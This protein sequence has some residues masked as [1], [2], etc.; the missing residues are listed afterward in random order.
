MLGLRISFLHTIISMRRVI[1]LA[2]GMC[3]PATATADFGCSSAVELE[4]SLF[5]PPGPAF[6]P[7]SSACSPSLP[8]NFNSSPPNSPSAAASFPTNNHP[9]QNHFLKIK[10]KGPNLNSVLEV[11]GVLL[12]CY[13]IRN[14]NSNC[15]LCCSDKKTELKVL[16][17]IASKFC[18][19]KNIVPLLVS[20]F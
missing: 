16:K 2:G 10:K 11:L 20:P 7:S 4:P 18:K 8:G 13:P 9:N 12:T 15:F 6:S 17:G 14:S 1:T 5:K 3:F 19:M